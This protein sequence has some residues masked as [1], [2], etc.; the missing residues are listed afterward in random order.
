MKNTINKYSSNIFSII[1]LTFFLLIAGGSEDESDRLSSKFKISKEEVDRCKASFPKAEQILT[2]LEKQE[3]GFFG[4]WS[5]TCD[6]LIVDY[7]EYH[8]N[9]EYLIYALQNDIEPKSEKFNIY[10]QEQ[11]K[12]KQEEERKKKE[13][14]AEINKAIIAGSRAKNTFPTNIYEEAC[15]RNWKACFDNAD[16]VNIHDIT[17]KWLYK[18]KSMAE[19]QATY[20]DVDWGGWSVI[21]FGGYINGNSIHTNSTITLT[22]NHAKYQNGFGARV[23]AKTNCLINLNNEEIIVWLSQ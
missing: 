22:D 5:K 12:K 3:S 18:C 10:V 6:D 9:E 19:A 17:F 16:Y 2:L 13:F 21:N 11:S 15:K 14:E 23:K 7:H 1:I 4:L 20:G 8:R